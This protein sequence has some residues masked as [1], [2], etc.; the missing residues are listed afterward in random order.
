VIAGQLEHTSQTFHGYIRYPGGSI[1]EYDEPHAG[2]A[3]SGTGLGTIPANINL[4]GDTAGYYFDASGNEHGFI[5]YRN[6]AF[7]T[8]DPPNTLGTMICLETCLTDDG[9][10]TG[11]YFDGTR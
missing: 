7:V 11:F 8:V 2:N 4:Q 5:R 6:G 9:T 3:M 1:F 10:V